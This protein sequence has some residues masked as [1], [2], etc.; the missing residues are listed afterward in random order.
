MTSWALWGTIV[1]AVTVALGALLGLLIKVILERNAKKNSTEQGELIAVNETKKSRAASLPDAMQ[2]ILGI[3]VVI[4][5]ILGTFNLS[6]GYTINILVAIVSVVL[7]TVVGELCDLDGLVNRL[8]AW[9]E[10]KMKGKGGRVA[11]GF[12]TATLLFCV[13]AMTVSGAI[14]SGVDHR[15]EIYYA[16]AMIDTVSAVIFASS[17]GVGVIFSAIGVFAV[18]GTLTGI[19]WLA[20]GAIPAYI[21]NE[22]IGVGS[23]LIIGIGTN[24]MGL[25]KLKVMNYVPSMF[26][27]I[28][29]GPLY[30]LIF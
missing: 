21:T 23:L 20:A 28:A 9:I 18:Q 8:G 1:N 7:G 13:G 11:E 25:T 26:V 27:P 22:M 2:K 12:V 3:C 5:G 16:K 29:L 14:Q 19:A 4:I 10:K 24:L 17:L 6:T 15:H 30:N